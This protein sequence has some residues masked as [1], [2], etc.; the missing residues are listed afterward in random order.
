F[1]EHWLRT[2]AD[3]PIGSAELCERLTMSGLEVEE[4]SPAGPPFSGVVV[5]RIERVDAHPNADRLK[6]CVVDIG[7]PERLSIVC[8][9]PNAAAGMKAPCATIG[10]KLPGGLTITRASVRGVESQGMLCSA[11]ELG[12]AD[13]A[14]GLLALAPDA[15]VGADLRDALDLDDTLIT[16]KLTPNRADCLSIL[17]IAREVAALTGTTLTPPPAADVPVATPAAR[18]VRVEDPAACPRFVSRTIEGID[19]RGATPE[20]M[21]QRLERCGVRSISA[22]VDVTNYVM[23]ELGQPLHAY[24]DRLLDGSIVVRFARPG[25]KLTLLNGQVLDL[26]RDMLLVAD[27]A[28]PLGLAGIM[29]GEHSGISDTTTTVL[30]EG[31]FW[32]PSIIQGRSRRLGFVSDA[33]YRFERGVDFGGC[34]RA[35][36]R[37]TQLIVEI[38]GGRAG[39]IGDVQ[40][41]MPRRDPVRVRPARVTRLLGVEIPDAAIAAMFERLRFAY[42]RDGDNFFVTPPSYRFDLV[43]EEDFVEEI[44][45]LH[46]YDAIPATA[47][48]HVQTMLPVVEDAVAPIAIKQRLVARGWQEVITFSFVSSGWETTLFPESGPRTPP[49]AVLNPI[50]SHLDVM[51]TT[52]AGGLIDVLSTNLARKQDRVRIFEVGRCFA[53]AGA[54][55]EQP[56]QL[57]GL[58]YGDALPEQWGAPRR[59][60]DLF[61]VKEDLEALVAPRALT[62]ERAEHPALHPGRAAQVLLDGEP[63]GWLGELHPRAVRAFD[64]PRAPVL[65]EVA[66]GPLLRRSLPRAQPVSRLPAVRRDLAL[67]VDEALPAQALL[68]ALTEAKPSVVD[69][70]RLFD[71]YRGPGIGPGKKSLAILVLI[72]D[73]ERTLTDAEIEANLSVLRQVAIDRFGAT[74]RQQAP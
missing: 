64:L 34:R 24:D 28:K 14:S 33:G 9:A 40:G 41:S 56:L 1:S 19:A 20:W 66:L 5:G 71:V 52:L 11:K 22:V 4:A 47:A 30:L 50:A 57:G 67:V 2:M 31:A 68:T 16:L 17:G 73:T 23:L 74:L 25:E 69:D 43:I 18:E 49:V 26:E 55:Y 3:P 51:R 12:I 8:G 70:I 27:S 61:D 39:P 44:A 63:I 54:G 62:T 6:V 46:G 37:A 58:A 21:K 65:F 72:Q 53:R 36:E 29:G 32:S 60:V 13:D 15:I 45:R 59:G 48:K 38:C 10:A 7:T 35:V 42:K